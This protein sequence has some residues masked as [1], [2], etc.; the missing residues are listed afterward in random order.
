LTCLKT[1][2]RNFDASGPRAPKSD[3]FYRVLKKLLPCIATNTN[4]PLEGGTK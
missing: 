4:P 3:T 1:L 2:V